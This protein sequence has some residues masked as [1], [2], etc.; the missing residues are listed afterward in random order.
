MFPDHIFFIDIT[1]FV[2]F[3]LIQFFIVINYSGYRTNLNLSI[4]LFVSIKVCYNRT[5]F[6][7]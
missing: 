7:Y 5:F 3:G 1:E 2:W 4:L 6:N